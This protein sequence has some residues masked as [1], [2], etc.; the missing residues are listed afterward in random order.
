[1]SQPTLLVPSALTEEQQREYA[2]MNFETHRLWQL[3][4]Y[5]PNLVI[6]DI[7]KDSQ[8]DCW[9]EPP[10]VLT[11]LFYLFE[12]GKALYEESYNALVEDLQ[13]IVDAANEQLLYWH[14]ADVSANQLLLW[15][16]TDYLW[17]IHVPLRQEQYTQQLQNGLRIRYLDHFRLDYKGIR[18]TFQEIRLVSRDSPPRLVI[19]EGTELTYSWTTAVWETTLTNPKQNLVN[20][21]VYHD[22]PLSP[23]NPE[24]IELLQARSLEPLV[25][26]LLSRLSDPLPP[27]LDNS[28]ETE[29]STNPDDGWGETTNQGPCWCRLEVC[30]CGYRPDTPPTPPNVT[31][32]V[33]GSNHLPL[34]GGIEHP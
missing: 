9:C 5:Y 15:T 24:L 7:S 6:C 2:R 3:N 25:P 14:L 32:W 18:L 19:T 8:V 1:M 33:P 21:R 26:S 4:W 22:P 29:E 27:S 34:S 13:G 12:F 20:P 28:I 31:L 23:T 30:T 16:N 11:H 10:V 17:F